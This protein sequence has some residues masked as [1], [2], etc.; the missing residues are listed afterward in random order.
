MYKLDKNSYLHFCEENRQLYDP[1]KYPTHP[2]N[3]VNFEKWIN[4][5]RE[6]LP[7]ETS[8]G[9]KN[10]TKHV[11][12]STFLAK[13][14]DMAEEIK[15]FIIRKRDEGNPYDKVYFQVNNYIDKSNFW[16]ATYIFPYVNDYVTDIIVGS[17]YPIDIFS[18]CKRILM[19]TPDDASYSGSQ[20]TDFALTRIKYFYNQ[21]G[22][23]GKNVK[24]DVMF[25]IPYISEM[26][27]NTITSS[28][29][30]Y[31]IGI[32]IPSVTEKFY[33]FKVEPE[34]RKYFEYDNRDNHTIYFDHKLPDTTSI[35]QEIYSIGQG[36]GEKG[37]DY[38]Y[39]PINLISGCEDIPSIFF[40]NK[41][42][43][44]GRYYYNDIADELPRMCPFPFYKGEIYTYKG[45]HITSIKNIKE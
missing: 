32:C 23:L 8:I 10:A 29:Y 27:V 20:I 2:P 16:V 24:I 13:C 30:D 35:Y 9:F 37:V 42:I 38:Q 31:P 12:L 45:D 19:I 17:K 6:G 25:A 18:G 5:H 34:M 15:N 43:N 28:V 22:D 11:S 39:E 4:H 26:A 3:Q 14:R 7:R 21:S 36:F 44:K 33:T 1:S 41:D 40:R